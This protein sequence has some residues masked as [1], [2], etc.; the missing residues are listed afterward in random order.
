MRDLRRLCALFALNVALA[1][2][3]PPQPV[4]AEVCAECFDFYASCCG[5]GS[6]FAHTFDHAPPACDASGYCGV[7]VGYRDDD[8][9]TV[10]PGVC[11]H[12]HS[13]CGGE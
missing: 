6:G 2:A 7:S 9:A 5:G 8:H 1:F 4:A 11:R 3:A 10:Y 13:L 12:Y